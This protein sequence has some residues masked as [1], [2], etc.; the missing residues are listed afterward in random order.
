MTKTL[1]FILALLV[2]ISCSGN[3]KNNI[4]QLKVS[5]KEFYQEQMRQKNFQLEM[6]GPCVDALEDTI[7]K[8]SIAYIE[9][10]TITDTKAV[11][12]FKFI[13]S[14]CQE[15]LGNYTIKDKV[16]TFKYERVNDELCA[17][18]CMYQYTLTINEP[19]GKYTMIEIVEK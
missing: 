11:V 7:H 3:N 9:S 6:N 12:K 16:L 10:E 15:F 2:I 4:K 14:C 8:R 13:S 18:L 5:K 17:C 1:I 19:K